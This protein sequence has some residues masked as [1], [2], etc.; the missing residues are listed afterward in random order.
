[1]RASATETRTEI[2]IDTTVTVTTEG[3]IIAHA[4]VRSH[5]NAQHTRVGLLHGD[6]TGWWITDSTGT[7]VVMADRTR[8]LVLQSF[9]D[10]LTGDA[11][12]WAA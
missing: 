5:G 10:Q 3:R 2:V 4:I 6:R 12:K 7:N 8:T 1:M 11:A 9:A